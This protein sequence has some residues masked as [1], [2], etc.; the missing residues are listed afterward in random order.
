MN[1]DV[2]ESPGPESGPIQQPPPPVS[3]KFKTGKG[4]S[5]SWREQ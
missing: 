2:G 3:V 5:C 4:L 1:I